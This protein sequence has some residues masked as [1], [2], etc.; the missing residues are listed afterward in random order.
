MANRKIRE[1][2]PPTAVQREVLNFF[3]YTY[4]ETGI[5][6]TLRDVARHFGWMSPHAAA[7]HLKPLVKKG[8]LLKRSDNK[9]SRC[10]LPAVPERH[11]PC[12][13]HAANEESETTLKS[14]FA[15]VVPPPPES[16][17]HLDRWLRP[18]T[19]AVPDPLDGRSSHES[20]CTPSASESDADEDAPAKAFAAELAERTS[21][22]I[23]LCTGKAPS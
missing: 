17:R 22:L 14:V 6:P 9:S 18:V 23:L 10:Y 11:C 16:Q 2:D 15:A 4:R 20:D 3:I 1:G 7:A 5:P 8:A 21:T 12:C 13:G 19:E